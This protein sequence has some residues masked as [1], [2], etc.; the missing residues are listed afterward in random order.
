MALLEDIPIRSIRSVLNMHQFH[1]GFEE[2]PLNSLVI[3]IE[4]N[5]SKKSN[6][7]NIVNL[8]TNKFKEYKYKVWKQKHTKST[9]HMANAFRK[10]YPHVY[11]NLL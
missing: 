4:N 1:L 8:S 3:L 2:S 5:G 7:K 9:A 6:Y 11:I 10:R